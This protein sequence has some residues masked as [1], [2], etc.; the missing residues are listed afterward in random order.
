[1][2]F[3]LLPKLDRLRKG[4][5]LALAAAFLSLGLLGIVLPGLPATPFLLLASYFLLRSSPQLHARML[6]WPLVGP[7]LLD[8]QQHRGVRR[9]VKIRAVGIVIGTLLLTALLARPSWPIL[10]AMLALGSMGI[11][12]IICLPKMLDAGDRNSAPNNLLPVAEYTREFHEPL[13]HAHQ[14]HLAHEAG[15]LLR[16]WRIRA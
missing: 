1:V 13:A 2:G 16:R 11:G 5:F 7:V 9:R 10:T 6:A 12:V 8:W 15:G 4:I 3:N 14:S